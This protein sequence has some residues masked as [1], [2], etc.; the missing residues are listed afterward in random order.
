MPELIYNQ[1]QIPKEQ[2]R[3]G[4]RSSAAVGCGWIALYNALT[5]LGK[6]VN[7]PALIRR[8]ERALPLVNGNAGT[9]AATPVFLLRSLGFST[10]TTA[11]PRQFDSLAKEAPV[12]I[13][14][15]YW[16]TKWRI[17]SHFVALRYENGQF[18]GY[19]TYTNSTGPDPYGPSLRAFLRTQ[20]Y[21]G[22]ILTGIHPP[23]QKTHPVGTGQPSIPKN[24]P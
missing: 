16:R 2:Y 1:T 9:F 15:Y 22:C 19:N 12:C 24:D 11:D 8:L 7:I 4:F 21:F 14:F 18:W 20:G 10:H 5:L 13:L 17:G 23:A 6:R 3:Y